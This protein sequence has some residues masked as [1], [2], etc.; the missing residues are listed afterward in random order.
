MNGS[1]KPR[2]LCAV[3][4][5]DNSLR[6]HEDRLGHCV[7]P[8]ADI[9]A[10]FQ[11]SP[12]E[13]TAARNALVGKLKKAGKE[14]EA[15]RVKALPKPSLPAWAVNQ[16]YW[17]HRK[18]FEQLIDAG[19]RFRKAQGAQLSG[20]NADLRG[21][22]DARREALSGLT[23][24]AAAVLKQAGHNA[25][26]DLTRRVTTTL[27]ALATYGAH[28]GAPP[29]GRLTDDIDP[30]GFEA[31]AALVPQVGRSKRAD[32]EPSRVIPFQQKREPKA[33]KKKGSPEEEARRR[34]EERKAALAA[35]KTAL[36]ESERSLRD[37][38]KDAEQAEADLKKAAA[39]AKEAEKE[40]ADIEKQFE[41]ASAA[42]DEARQEARRVAS[43][44]EEAAQAVEDAERAVENAKRELEK[45][46]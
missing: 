23:R 3:P 2:K 25:T 36:T 12:A 26:P 31:L 34:E 28:P 11:L 30:P 14:E 41:K 10:L 45:L 40:K 27:E 1:R 46:S 17:R 39:R 9:D 29:A 16:L 44:A 18:A 8:T 5:A 38:K 13:F 24:L 6:G 19:E 42:A 21:T 20:K 4:A 35:A 43:K 37:A 32:A 22:L 7:K 33:G 15:D